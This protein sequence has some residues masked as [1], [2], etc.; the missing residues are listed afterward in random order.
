VTFLKFSA[1]QY[2]EI[3]R[4]AYAWTGNVATWAEGVHEALGPSLDLGQGTLVVIV[5]L[6]EGKVEIRHLASRAGASR[7]HHAV[8]RL[9]AL[10]AP[11]KLREAF[12]NGR[13]VGSSSGHYDDAD[14]SKMQSRA[15]GAQTRDAV[16]WCV[17]DAVDHGFMVVAPSREQLTIPRTSPVVRRLG[18][19]IATGLRLQRV[20]ASASLEDPA[21]EAIFDVD[22]R[23]QHVDGMAR[24]PNALARLRQSVLARARSSASEPD[25]VDP[26]WSAVIAGR[27]S[28]VDRFDAD[29]RR[30]V[31][32]YRN[33][34][35]V[36][37]PRRLTPREERVTTLAAVGR[38]NKEIAFELGVSQS[39]VATLLAAALA[40][41][42]LESR[43]LLPLFWQDLHG[44][45]WAVTDTEA[46]LI[47][48]SR[49]EGTTDISALTPAERAVADG[50]LRGLS[51]RQIARARSCSRHTVAKQVTAIYRKL[52]VRSRIELASQLSRHAADPSERVEG[53]DLDFSP[54]LTSSQL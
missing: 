4:A 23:A 43:T 11:G 14:V 20:V 37:D 17:Q 15:R 42:G 45:A 6:P 41:L 12:F 22:G 47:A 32:A 31:L 19:H 33:P 3:T 38:A 53:D 35:G 24:A 10:L 21:V 26:A 8:V 34:P 13:V 5:G 28:L 49:P 18:A 2:L 9:S 40:K 36:L 27:W 1:E 29:G 51:D 52:G 7:V 16:G 54:Q 25:A 48:L 46:A 44:H 30:F 50:L 39:T